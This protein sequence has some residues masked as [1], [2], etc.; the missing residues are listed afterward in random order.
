MAADAGVRIYPVGIGSS[1]GAVI[2]LEGYQV[3]TQLN[4]PLLQEIA[5]LTNG[6]YYQAADQEVLEEI[7]D[8]IDLQLTIEGENT[9]VTSLFAGAGLLVFLFGGLLSLLWFGR[10]PV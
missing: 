6:D 9:E 3:Q 10:M 1:D 2:E 5:S 8:T 4:E 7:Y